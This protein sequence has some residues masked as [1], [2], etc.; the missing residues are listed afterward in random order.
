M[1]NSKTL[2]LHKNCVHR[3]SGGRDCAISAPRRLA[4]TIVELFILFIFDLFI[5]LPGGGMDYYNHIC[6]LTASVER[7]HLLQN[8][9]HDEGSL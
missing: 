1:K 4:D 3:R 8:S 2:K 9:F 5:G 6:G 7:G